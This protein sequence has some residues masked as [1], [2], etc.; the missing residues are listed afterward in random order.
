MTKAL[1]HHFLKDVTSCPSCSQG[2]EA[3]GDAGDGAAARQEHEQ[4]AHVAVSHRGGA[5]QARG[6]QRLPR[7]RDPEETGRAAGG[8]RLTILNINF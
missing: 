3:E 1:E 6:L 5:R 2:E 4:P 7:R 8:R